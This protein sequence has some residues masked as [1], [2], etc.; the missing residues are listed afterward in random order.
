MSNGNFGSGIIGFILG[1]LSFG[2]FAVFK[3]KKAQQIDYTIHDAD[4]TEIARVTKK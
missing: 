4:H 1:I 3:R 2:L